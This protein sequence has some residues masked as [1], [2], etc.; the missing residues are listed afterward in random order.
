MSP[1]RTSP[2]VVVGATR[3]LRPAVERLVA[4]ATPVV[5]VART[6]GDLTAM[7][8]GLG[9]GFTPLGVDATER[10]FAARI[11]VA[12]GVVAYA[13][14]TGEPVLQALRS[15]SAGPVV[16]VVTSGVA[17]PGPVDWT[18]ADLPPAP[19]VRR[20]VLGWA[21]RRWHSPEEISSAALDL[22]AAESDEDRVLGAVRPW[23]DRPA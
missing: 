20:L 22:L 3:I 2:V 23:Q 21:Q 8:D 11:R 7:A 17:E 1:R 19:G 18:V 15:V 6:R 13:P 10:A 5:G 16:L 14:A 12:S 4:S 9:P